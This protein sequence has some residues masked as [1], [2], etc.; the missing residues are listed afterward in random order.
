MTNIVKKLT[1]CE[2]CRRRR[3]KA[4]KI[5]EN[6]NA[7]KRREKTAKQARFADSRAAE[8][9]TSNERSDISPADARRLAESRPSWGR[10]GRYTG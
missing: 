7:R 2:G 10:G 1:G 9:D 5:W 3:E 4:K 8:S 6:W